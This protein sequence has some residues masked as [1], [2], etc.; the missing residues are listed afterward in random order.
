MQA[1]FIQRHQKSDYEVEILKE[2]IEHKKWADGEISE[3][4]T[5]IHRGCNKNMA[6]SQLETVLSN[7]EERI[8]TLQNLNKKNLA[9]NHLLRRDGLVSAIS[10]TVGEVKKFIDIML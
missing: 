7:L 10:K 1:H 3:L 6:R 4:Q 8:G 9:P 5:S 2:S